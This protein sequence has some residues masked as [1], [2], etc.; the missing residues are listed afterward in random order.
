[1]DE[2]VMGTILNQERVDN[3]Y[4]KLSR[5]IDSW[6]E[7]VVRYRHKYP[8][9][10]K[11]PVEQAIRLVKVAPAVLHLLI[12]L[13]NH[14]EISDRTKR[15]VGGAVAYFIVPIDLIPEG[16]VGPV[17]Y[18]D[19]V[20]VGLVL[21]DRLLNGDDEQEKAIIADLWRGTEEELNALRALVQIAD[22]IRHLEKYLKKTFPRWF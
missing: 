19:D 14:E 17:G 7:N 4:D 20:L 9:L 1:M 2:R 22:V 6:D 18:V 5:K 8:L 10:R 3:F 21:I 13:V 16:V 11:L 12:S 15:I